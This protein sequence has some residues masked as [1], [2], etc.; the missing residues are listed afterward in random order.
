MNIGLLHYSVPPVVGGVETILAKHAVLMMEAGHNVCAIAGRGAQF[1]PRIEFHQIPLVDSVQA[2]VLAV[3]SELDQGMVSAKFDSLVAEI[4]SNLNPLLSELDLLIAHNVCSLHKNLAL[5]AALRERTERAQRPA[6]ILWHHD[7]AWTTPRYRDELHNGY[8]WD[9]IRQ[10]W[11]ATTHVAVSEFRR[12]EL[13][14]LLGKRPDQIQV[15]PNGVS[16]AQVLALNTQTIELA[17]RLELL[18]ASPF[19]LLPVRITRRKN[20]E[21]AIRTLAELRKNFPRVK[22]VIT[23]PV[24]PHNITNIEYF[25]RLKNLTEELSLTTCVHFLADAEKSYLPEDVVYGLLRMSDLL[26]L[27]SFEEG[28]GLP[29]IEASQANVPVFCSGIDPLR[30]LAGN[31]AQYFSPESDPKHLASRIAKHL[32]TSSVFHLRT[33]L[34]RYDWN[35]VYKETIEP[36]LLETG[37]NR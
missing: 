32:E 24:G 27:P 8:P 6:L 9:L 18:T 37:E 7:L 15:I 4:A 14:D 34:R 10:D 13:A 21:L 29:V 25:K 20:I 35:C 5:T 28:F 11:P 31:E 23:G 26:L 3:K 19:I 16:V 12:I 30:E 1:D 33:N 22:L 2:N 17:A 36:L